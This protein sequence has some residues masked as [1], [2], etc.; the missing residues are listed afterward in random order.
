M[1]ADALRC[2]LPQVR[3]GPGDADFVHLAMFQPLPHTGEP[4][5]ARPSSPLLCVLALTPR[6]PAVAQLTSVRAGMT[7]DAPL[8][9]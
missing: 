2:A 9:E 1:A 6:A 8:C 4:I 5:E 3:V 7:R